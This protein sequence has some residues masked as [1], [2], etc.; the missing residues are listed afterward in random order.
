MAATSR[1]YSLRVVFMLNDWVFWIA[2]LYMLRNDGNGQGGEAKSG[3][4]EEDE[5]RAHAGAGGCRGRRP[6]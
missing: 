4:R 2:R 3:R 5:R 6:D 1:E